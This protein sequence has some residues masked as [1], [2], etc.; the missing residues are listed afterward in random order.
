VWYRVSLDSTFYVDVNGVKPNVYD[1]IREKS[2]N[3]KTILVFL[4]GSP[5]QIS[6]WKYLVEYFREYYRVI[7][8]DL[9]GYGES[10]KPERV[11]LE[12][13]LSDNKC[14]LE[15]LGVRDNDVVLIGHSFGGVVAQEYA[16]RYSIASLVLI[17][18]LTRFKPDIIDYIVWY[19]PSLFWRKLF[20]TENILARKMYRKIFF[21]NKTPDSVYEE[22]IRDN[23]GYLENLPPHVFLGI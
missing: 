17:G 6:N 3:S 2:Y 1:S 14:L 11:S 20:F 18:S 4:H 21:S 12:D 5:G 9:R 23:K 10:S 15:K 19:L 16:A 22:F 8:Y 13:Y 7:A